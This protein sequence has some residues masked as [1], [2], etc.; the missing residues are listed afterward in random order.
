MRTGRPL[1]RRPIP[2]DDHATKRFHNSPVVLN[3]VPSSR[4][5]ASRFVPSGSTNCGR[6]AQKKKRDPE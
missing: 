5:A 3:T 1:K 2:A 4:N 6:R